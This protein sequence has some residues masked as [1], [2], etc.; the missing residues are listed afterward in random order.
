MSDLY[1]STYCNF[2]HRLS[3]GKPIDH[4]CRIIPPAALRAERDGDVETAN[5]ILRNTPVRMMRR[6]V[7]A[8][9]RCHC[10]H[11]L[12]RAT[13]DRYEKPARVCVGCSMLPAFCKCVLA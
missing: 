2:A 12:R 5:W 8:D 7:K 9:K 4:E 1:V 13:A 10:G 6:G 3:D 11:G